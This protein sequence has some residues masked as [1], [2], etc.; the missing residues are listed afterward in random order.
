MKSLRTLMLGEVFP[1]AKM[2]CLQKPPPAL[3]RPKKYW[4]NVFLD[5]NWFKLDQFYPCPEVKSVS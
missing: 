1:V 3:L 5:N 4:F 2:A